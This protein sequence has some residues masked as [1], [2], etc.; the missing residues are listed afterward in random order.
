MSAAPGDR[1]AASP[2]Y[3]EISADQRAE[4]NWRTLPE[5]DQ[6]YSVDEL[7]PSLREPSVPGF[8]AAEAATTTT[9]ATAAAAVTAAVAAATTADVGR[10]VNQWIAIREQLVTAAGAVDRLLLAAGS[11][12]D[13][14][15]RDAAHSGNARGSPPSAAAA[16][17]AAS[18][19]VAAGTE[20]AT[21]NSNLAAVG[22]GSATQRT[23]AELSS[24]PSS[25]EHYVYTAAANSGNV[26]SSGA[27]LRRVLELIGFKHSLNI[28]PV[29]TSW[30]LEY[31][32]L[33]GDIYSTSYRV[34]FSSPGL[35][36]SAV[37][38]GTLDFS[39]NAAQVNAGRHGGVAVLLLAHELGMPW[40]DAVAQG[41]A[42]S[43][44]VDKFIWLR[45]RCTA[46]L[47]DDI[48]NFAARSGSVAMLQLLQQEG[49][50]FI[51][52]AAIGAAEAGHLHVL[53][54]LHAERCAIG[55][56]RA[57]CAAAGRAHATTFAWLHSIGCVSVQLHGGRLLSSIAQGGSVE[58]L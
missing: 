1:A 41:V 13:R 49:L 36:S 58:I 30:K 27:V 20:A 50:V 7:S 53:Q 39:F 45:E 3:Q 4:L 6:A 42:K 37:S 12:S 28:A 38:S 25:D 23:D 48:A 57:A 29:C 22:Q 34:I 54:F 44:S 52:T 24:R 19:S 33:F 40:S 8:S 43:G 21:I 16:V 17:S 46:V 56:L 26:L 2:P 32:Q 35:L 14:Q 47:P 51:G 55:D 18:A 11:S 5:A 10:N 9:T 31:R 15:M